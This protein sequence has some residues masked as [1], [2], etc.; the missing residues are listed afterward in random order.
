MRKCAG[1][2]VFLIL[3]DGGTFWSLYFSA[4]RELAV[5]VPSK[6]GRAGAGGVGGRSTAPDKKIMPM[7]E[8][9]L[10]SP[11]PQPPTL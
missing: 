11:L 3:A 7:K 5:K 8:K 4:S 2:L 6:C 1:D 9:F 10:S